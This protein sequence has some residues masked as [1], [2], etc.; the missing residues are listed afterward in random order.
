MYSGMSALEIAEFALAMI[1]A[2]FAIFVS[3]SAY[4]KKKD[5][6]HPDDLDG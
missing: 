2:G 6:H 3:I 4:L 5:R 1:L